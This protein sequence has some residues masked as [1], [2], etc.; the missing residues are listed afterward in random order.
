[1]RR[2][3]WPVFFCAIGIGACFVNEALP[4]VQEAQRLQQQSDANAQ[5][6]AKLRLLASL[7]IGIKIRH[8]PNPA[9]P[10]VGGRSGFNFT[11]P[12]TT[13]VQTIRG[14]VKIEE[15]GAFAWEN[16]RW[17]FSNF[18][19][20]PYSEVDFADW[21]SC[22]NARLLPGR[23]CSDAHNWSGRRALEAGK[24]MWYFI[25][26]DAQGKRVKGEAI[27]QHLGAFGHHLP[28]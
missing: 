20:K 27:I 3:L 15:F 4:G 14:S 26:V 17:V 9:R 1:M 28:K 22:P 2:I 10:R 8:S 11:W 6:N 23:V 19:G 13:S 5:L 21:Y 12:Y 16:G 24:T 18:T 25:G 7:P